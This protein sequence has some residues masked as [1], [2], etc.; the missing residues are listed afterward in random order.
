MAFCEER[1]TTLY[2]ELGPWFRSGT[3]Y[4]DSLG[5]SVKNWAKNGGGDTVS[6]TAQITV[7]VSLIDHEVGSDIQG[8]T[9]YVGFVPDQ[10]TCLGSW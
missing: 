3:T 4:P 9:V 6:E 7:A 10:P 2:S 1:G 8:T 5:I